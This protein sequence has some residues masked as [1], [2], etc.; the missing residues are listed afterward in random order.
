[1]G[2]APPGTMLEEER[3]GGKE[4]PFFFVTLAMKPAEPV[5]SAEETALVI[6]TVAV[7]FRRRARGEIRPR[8]PD[9]VLHAVVFGRRYKRSVFVKHYC[10]EYR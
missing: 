4:I 6:P 2:E 5:V 8:V 7:S 3:T 1:M 10:S 9:P